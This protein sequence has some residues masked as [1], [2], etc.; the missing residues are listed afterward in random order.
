MDE[1]KKYLRFPD[2]ET[3]TE[4]TSVLEKHDIPFELDDVSARFQLVQSTVNIESP[5]I[6]K[7]RDEDVDSA[8]K[9]FESEI[10]E[11]VKN[12]APDHYLYTF[13]DKDILDVIANQS[14]WTKVEI[15]LAMQIAR[16]RKLDLS[17][18]SIKSAKKVTPPKRNLTVTMEDKAKYK[19]Y[20][21]ILLALLGIYIAIQLFNGTYTAIQ[22]G[23]IKSSIFYYAYALVNI[24]LFYNIAQYHRVY[25]LAVMIYAAFLTSELL[26]AH[27][28]ESFIVSLILDGMVLAL[29]IF[30]STKLFPKIQVNS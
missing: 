19:V 30:L 16:E 13:S 6:L 29:S 3:A 22:H 14:D 25:G 28:A 21:N 4:F 5:F 23:L 27:S 7:I 18:E 17:A 20:N 26:K 10:D 15:K 1:F 2:I 12:I 11:E 24:Y 8:G 9:L